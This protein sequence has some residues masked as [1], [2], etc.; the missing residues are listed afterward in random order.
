VCSNVGKVDGKSDGK[1]EGKL[2]GEK[3]RPCDGVTEGNCDGSKDGFCEG[4]ELRPGGVGL[5]EGF[6]VGRAWFEFGISSS[7]VPSIS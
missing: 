1:V 3:K 6:L 2:D 7:S 5:H 4:T